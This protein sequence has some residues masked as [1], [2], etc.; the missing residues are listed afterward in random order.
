VKAAIVKS[1]GATVQELAWGSLTWYASELLGNSKEMTVGRCV[2]EPGQEN[3]VHSHP[4]CEEVLHL[5][6]GS[7]SHTA[8][9]ETYV[10][11]PGDT[12]V[13]APHVRHNARNIGDDDAA[14][15]IAFSSANRKTVAD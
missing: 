6:Q 7:L 13:I 3:P 8:D 15:Y 14:M 2:I 9:E 4:N 1:D 11:E 5:I 10:L 12:I